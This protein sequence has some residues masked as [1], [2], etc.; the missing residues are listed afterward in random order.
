MGDF[1]KE[2]DI[3]ERYFPEGT[4]HQDVFFKLG[5]IQF[6][7]DKAKSDKCY[8]ER[9]FDFRTAAM[10]FNDEACINEPDPTHSIDEERFFGI[11]VPTSDAMSEEAYIGEVNHVLY[12]VYTERALDDDDRNIIGLL[13]DKNAIVLLNKSDLSPVLTSEELKNACGRDVISIS[14]RDEQGID[15]FVSEIKKMFG[16]GAI[17]KKEE[18]F[19]S[20]LRHKELLQ[21]AYDSLK[22]V[23]KSI[24]LGMSEDF[25]SIDLMNAYTSLGGIIGEEIDDDLADKI[26][27][28]FCMGK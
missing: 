26:F 9:G 1:I 22:E 15:V 7:W 4:E 8:A 23:L 20:K 27:K 11:G 3:D 21:S 10:V 6:V 12:V 5:D 28:E 16:L 24:D 18:I 2:E 17:E 13:K 19:I 14:A 25:F